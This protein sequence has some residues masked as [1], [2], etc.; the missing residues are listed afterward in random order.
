[1]KEG[2]AYMANFSKLVTTTKG[3]ELIVKIL[4]G[5]LSVEP[6]SPFSKIVTSSA[7]YE[8][9]QIESLTV[10]DQVQQY[11]LVS[12]VTKQNKTTV[13]IHG[14]M[15]NST[16][17][18]GYR[19]NTVGVFFID[20][21]DSQEY[22]FGA[23]IHQPTSEAPT[24]DFIFPFN[25][26]TTTGLMFDLLASV[27]NTDNIN[28]NVDP[29]AVVTI[30]TL[31]LHNISETAHENRFAAESG[32]RNSQING[33]RDELI[34]SIE[35]NTNQISTLQERI[36]KI[37]LL[38][39][40]I[41]ITAM[42]G[43]ELQANYGNVSQLVETPSINDYVFLQDATVWSISSI[44]ENGDISWG[45]VINFDTDISGK[46]DKI[47]SG[48][49]GNFVIQDIAGNSAPSDFSPQD[50]IDMMSNPNILHNWDFR[51]PVNQRGLLEYTAGRIIDRW[52]LH[53]PNILRLNIM[54]GFIRLAKNI[55][56]GAVQ[57][58]QFIEFPE[59]LYGQTFTLSILYRTT[60]NNIVLA[61]PELTP[62]STVLEPS[63]NWRIGKMTFTA[64]PN[65]SG[66]FVAIHVPGETLADEFIDIQAVKLEV[67]ST[68]TLANDPPM[69]FGRELAI[70]QR[71]LFVAPISIVLR[72]T[73][74]N[75]DNISTY[76]PLPT[77]MRINPS[78]SGVFQIRQL[79]NTIISNVTI[80]GSLVSGN[81]LWLNTL[82]PAHGG[83]DV[84]LFIASG[85]IFSA[86]L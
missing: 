84:T 67:G 86:E 78:I 82:V 53:F 41:P 28:L 52:L 47:E 40:K 13:E 2:V 56:G 45:K 4:A 9:S 3:H 20:P 18:L 76:L 23:A 75:A 42:N 49:A 68:S 69:D 58:R 73:N 19:L 21:S 71:Y 62:V 34:I 16:L 27:G 8:L 55:N 64:L 25:G 74:F 44:D 22:L 7:I 37:Q 81:G 59:K 72:L 33:L 30:K 61:V 1:L 46:M 15:N 6:Q 63:S 65:N 14:G 36:D 24:G 12:S 70:C 80:N 85:N 32:I 54:D 57:L 79:D 31:Q 50:L 5:K 38:G 10:L 48:N 35:E 17:T 51:N 29:A 83:N 26:L 11:T 39:R 60:L 77:T 43:T 66:A